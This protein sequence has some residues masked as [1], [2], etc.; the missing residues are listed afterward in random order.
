M[1]CSSC[2]R[3]VTSALLKVSDV[4]AVEVD[5]AHGMVNVTTQSVS[6][7]S[8][9]AMVEALSAAG[10]EANPVSAP[11]CAVEQGSATQNQANSCGQGGAGPRRAGGCC[12]G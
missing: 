2:V 4:S 3:S 8:V 7:A 6:I 5:L 1:S 12:C 11:A 10:Y 9:P